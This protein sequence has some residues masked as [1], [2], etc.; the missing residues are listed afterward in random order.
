MK[1]R[2]YQDFL[3]NT[4]EGKTTEVGWHAFLQGIFLTQ[5]LNPSPALQVG[6]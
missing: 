6:S 1:L 5:K 2:F 3:S 4:M